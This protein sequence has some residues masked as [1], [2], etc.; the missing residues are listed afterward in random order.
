MRKEFTV[1]NATFIYDNSIK[2]LKKTFEYDG[3]ESQSFNDIYDYRNAQT[4]KSAAV[5]LPTYL[6]CSIIL[7]FILVSLIIT[8][9]SSFDFVAT[10]LFNYI[11]LSAFG[12][13]AIKLLVDIILIQK[14]IIPGLSSSCFED[15]DNKMKEIDSLLAY[16]EFDNVKTFELVQNMHEDRDEAGWILMTTSVNPDETPLYDNLTRSFEFTDVES[17]RSGDNIEIN[18]IDRTISVRK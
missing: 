2:V 8:C 17:Y 3:F 15:A 5:L 11:F 16:K 4:I 10:N 18:C 13:F 6:L 7:I 1:K 9:C 14:R 12:I